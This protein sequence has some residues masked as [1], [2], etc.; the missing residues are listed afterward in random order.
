MILKFNNLSITRKNVTIILSV[1]LFAVIATIVLMGVRTILTF[2]ENMVSK[3]QTVAELMASY[4]AP[5][6][7]F[8]DNSQG[9]K[10]L[11]SLKAIPEVTAAAIYAKDGTLFAS[12]VKNPGTPVF[13]STPKAIQ[14]KGPS[15]TFEKGQLHLQRDIMGKDE[16]YG[17]ILI[18][19]TTSLLTQ[20]TTRFV[21]ISFA[22]LVIIFPGA[23]LLGTKLS[24]SLTTPILDLART[25]A[26]ISAKGD[27]SIRVEKRYNDEIGTLYES[28]NQMLD[29]ISQKD[30]EIRKLNENL[31]EKVQERTLDL[32][33]AKEHAELADK[34]KSTFLANMSHEIRTPMNAIIGYSRLLHRMILD[35]KQKEYLEIVK[36]S[37]MNLLSLIDDILDL[38][39]IEAGKMNLIYH[40]MNPI[41]LINEMEN[42]FRIKTKEKGIDF[43]IHIE[44]DVPPS[45]ILDETRLRQI[46]F[47]VVGNAVKFTEQGFVRLSVKKTVNHQDSSLI[48]LVFIIED[49]GIGIAEDQLEKIFKAFEQQASQDSKYGGTGLG[50]TI[51]RR[52]VEMM[53]G[54]ISV[55]SRLGE[56]TVFTIQL[57]EVE[58]GSLRIPASTI[59]KTSEDAL[60]FKE[61]IVLV[62]EDNPYNMK[63]VHSLL[64]T[65]NIHVREAINGQEGITSLNTY[66]PLPHLILMD[67]KTPVMDGYIATERIKADERFQHIPIIALTADIMAADKE[68]AI[69]S[70]CD[71]FLPKPIDEEQLFACLM[72][73]LPY[74]SKKQVSAPLTHLIETFSLKNV[75]QPKTLFTH[76]TDAQAIALMDVLSYE[77]FDE[78]RKIED[79][80]ILDE[81]Q[82]F[83]SRLIEL[84]QQYQSDELEQYGNA[85]VNNVTHLNIVALKKI[86]HSFPRYVEAIGY[87]VN[88]PLNGVKL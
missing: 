20:Q 27:Y 31:E 11:S 2:Q 63:L 28:F 32:M 23:A 77:M 47:N 60:D 38:S 4:I 73:Y 69:K 61:S 49:T 1:V 58:I 74:A 12:Y 10:I 18:I 52:L 78:W 36:T 57:C 54:K 14:R 59:N 75:D 19:T 50:L 70:G 43:V 46:L 45:L 30:R 16:Y 7:D 9:E 21:L 44:S 17:K 22:F 34:A 79:S 26:I 85:I 56:G 51:T 67:M 40:P 83:G 8:E 80:M 62:V 25:A 53:K 41:S 84:A 71:G 24:K 88:N 64:E 39:K 13:L 76:L 42:I 29:T 81:W 35:P 82:S 33:K 15:A 65:R 68:R 66:T 6:I 86:V 5:V 3:I 48:N 72:K 55:S 87:R 37:G